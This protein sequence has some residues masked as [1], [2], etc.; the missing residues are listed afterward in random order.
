MN[1]RTFLFINF[2][3]GFVADII[4]NDLSR[5]PASQLFPSKIIK[6]LNTYFLNKSIIQA[7][8]YAGLTVVVV[9]IPTIILF[10]LYFDVF[11]NKLL[12]TIFSFI[13]GFISDII[14]DKL[15]IFGNTLKPFYKLAGSGLW[16]GLAIAFSVVIS[17]LIQIYLLPIL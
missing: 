11:K 3:V 13:T 15:N 1:T 12:F 6:S 17:Y 10:N 2:I 4:L 8:I 14:I 16:G 7:G 9:L 5:K